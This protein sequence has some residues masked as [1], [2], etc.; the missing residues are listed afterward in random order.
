[1]SLLY[2]LSWLAERV[3]GAARRAQPNVLTRYLEG[4]AGTYFS[5]QED[6]PALA[7]GSVPNEG[8]HARL[9][10]VAAARTVQRTGLDRLGVSAP[11]RL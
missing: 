3:S 1:M 9:W 5:C 8:Q 2:E 6:C 10:L 4:L 11:D 7:P